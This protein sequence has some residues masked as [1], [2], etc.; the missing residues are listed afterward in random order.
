MAALLIVELNEWEQYSTRLYCSHVVGQ[1]IKRRNCQILLFFDLLLLDF[2]QLFCAWYRIRRSPL[3]I[4]QRRRIRRSSV[5]PASN[6]MNVLSPFLENQ[7]TEDKHS[8]ATTIGSRRRRADAAD[9]TLCRSWKIR[10]RGL[11]TAHLLRP[12][13]PAKC[14]CN[15]VHTSR[16]PGHQRDKQ[17]HTARGGPLPTSPHSSLLISLLTPS[18]TFGLLSMPSKLKT[19][20]QFE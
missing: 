15:C 9:L 17:K 20:N 6:I 11:G 8:C 19:H 7:A 12:T 10:P 4:Y 16:L 13:F 18:V 3:S 5:N 2:L 14:Q 1:E